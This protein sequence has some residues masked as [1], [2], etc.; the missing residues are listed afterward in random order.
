MF[1]SFDQVKINAA[2]SKCG[3]AH[4]KTVHQ[5]RAEHNFRCFACGNQISVEDSQVRSALAN[6]DRVREELGRVVENR[7]IAVR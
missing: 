5:L 4:R 6:I 3:Y 2:C 7:S 1:E